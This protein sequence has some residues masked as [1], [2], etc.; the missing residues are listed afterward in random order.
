LAEIPEFLLKAILGL[1]ST[2]LVVKPG[3]GWVYAVYKMW[4]FLKPT[5]PARIETYRRVF[6]SY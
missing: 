4:G 5:N 2:H 3:E 6:F 1:S